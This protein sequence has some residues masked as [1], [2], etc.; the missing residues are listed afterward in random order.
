[1]RDFE[2]FFLNASSSSELFDW[3][4]RLRDSAGSGHV[5]SCFLDRESIPM[6]KAIELTLPELPPKRLVIRRMQW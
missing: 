2:S 5:S 4:G 3:T 6:K 1:L